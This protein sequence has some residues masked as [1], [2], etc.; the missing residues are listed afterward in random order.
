V[1]Q[2]RWE[3][4]GGVSFVVFFSALAIRG[5]AVGRPFS[6]V[7]GVSALLVVVGME[8]TSPRGWAPALPS[9]KWV[10]RLLAAGF[11]VFVFL[12]TVACVVAIARGDWGSFVY[13]GV[14]WVASIGALFFF[15][16]APSPV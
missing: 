1:T 15:V 8:V 12:S 4:V 5:L 6:V 7:V 16:Y 2:A 3:F 9:G 11:G 14:A 10:R 13:N